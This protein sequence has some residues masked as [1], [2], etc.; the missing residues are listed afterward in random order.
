MAG[1]PGGLI[2]WL[3]AAARDP[4]RWDVQMLMAQAAAEIIR[5]REELEK[6]RKDA[7]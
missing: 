1:Y 2:N 6:L 3:R 5:L 7:A 4:H